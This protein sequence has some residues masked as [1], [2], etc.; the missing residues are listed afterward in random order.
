[1]PRCSARCKQHRQVRGVVLSVPI[2][3]CD[4]R[5]PRRA[6]ACEQ[7]RALPATVAVRDHAQPGVS[8]HCFPQDLAGPVGAA[9]VH[10]YHLEFEALAE[11]G[12]NLVKQRENVVLLV[13]HRNDDRQ[14]D[15]SACARATGHFDSPDSSPWRRKVEI[16]PSLRCKA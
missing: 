12:V 10:V 8:R 11:R 15:D 4:P 1:M 2:E 7:R 9:V 5:A 13:P 6:H 16:I 3:R 14:F